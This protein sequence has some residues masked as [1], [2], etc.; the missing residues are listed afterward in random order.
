MALTLTQQP[1]PN[2]AGTVMMPHPERSIFPWNWAHYSRMETKF[3]HGSA[4][5]NVNGC[6]KNQIIVFTTIK[7]PRKCEGYTLQKVNIN[8]LLYRD[9]THTQ[10]LHKQ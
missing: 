7:K 3:P 6:R 4:F 9:D 1:L 2:T 5:V 10:I 8:Y